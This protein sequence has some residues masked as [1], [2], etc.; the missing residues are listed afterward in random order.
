MRNS[1]YPFANAT[2][3]L[4]FFLLKRPGQLEQPLKLSGSRAN[5]GLLL[6]AYAASDE[7]GVLASPHYSLHSKKL[8]TLGSDGL[9]I[10]ETNPGFWNERRPKTQRNNFRYVDKL[11]NR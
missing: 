4:A 9:A 10:D 3:E 1:N 7:S 2:R 6:S 11:I 8:K 5:V